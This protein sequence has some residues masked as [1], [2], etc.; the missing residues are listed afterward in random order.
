MRYLFLLALGCFGTISVLSQDSTYA[1]K[2]GFPKG[3]KVVILHVDD[4]GMSLDVNRGAIE[5]MTQGVASSCSVMMPCP[6]V[7]GY[8]HYL[9]EHPETDAGLHLT[10]TSEWK[11]YRWGPLAGRPAVPGLVDGE[12]A[13]WASVE[14]VVKHATPDEV[15]KEIRA[16]VERALAFGFRPTH[17]DS[18]MGTLFA[19]PAFIQRYVKVGMEYRIPVMFPGGHNTLIAQ[20]MKSTAADMQTARMVGK[21]LWAAGLPV[22]DDL[23][24]ESYAPHLP[25][26]LQ[27]TE[28]NLRKY[29]TQYYIDALKSV[30]PGITY[31]IMH[32]IKPTE[33]FASISDSGPIRQGDY[34][35]MMN[36]E[37]RKFIKDQGIIVTT[38]RDLMRRRAALQQ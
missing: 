12:G 22:I 32:C 33:V 30:K 31:I 11:D 3:A 14:D 8:F 16:Q 4:V 15:E 28:E 1:E 27:P 23:H 2:L 7:P 35:A 17:M 29:K 26:G 21:A 19:T 6:W 13:M 25:A 18:H 36:P 5:S 20:Q 38:M 9:M 10:L 34:L 37:L 24:N